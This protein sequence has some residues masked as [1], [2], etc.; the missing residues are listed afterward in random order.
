MSLDR[1]KIKLE[2]YNKN[3]EHIDYLIAKGIHPIEIM[4]RMIHI[5]L[6]LLYEGTKNRYPNESKNEIY[7]RM[8]NI[9]RNQLKLEKLKI[10]LG[11]N[12]IGEF[13]N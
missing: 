2:K 13:F 8:R 11:K 3:N 6:D 4:D 9:A 7:I 1:F 5:L 12:G 10:K